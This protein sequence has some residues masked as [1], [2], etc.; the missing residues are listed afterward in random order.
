[1]T[2]RGLY[3]RRRRSAPLMSRVLSRTFA[4]TGYEVTHEANGRTIS[5]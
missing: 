5:G 1:M 4:Y 2:V 3:E